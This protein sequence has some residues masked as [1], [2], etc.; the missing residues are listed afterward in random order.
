MSAASENDPFEEAS[1][2]HSSSQEKITRGLEDTGGNFS[3]D[4]QAGGVD[5]DL[6]FIESGLDELEKFHEPDDADLSNADTADPPDELPESGKPDHPTQ[7]RELSL[8]EEENRLREVLAKHDSPENTTVR[9]EKP[10]T[11]T[12][13]QT[14][15]KLQPLV[16]QALEIALE[17]SIPDMI[18][19]VE[20]AL[21]PKI[22]QQT[23]SVIANQLPGIV[24]KIVSREIEKFN[25]L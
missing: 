25:N 5:E 8:Q 21:V 17:A 3:E 19:R 22:T 4:T 18:N 6:S 20:S 23:E 10:E 15:E 16:S 1:E 12:G 9:G 2:D 11:S 24:D 13:E 14:L 7:D